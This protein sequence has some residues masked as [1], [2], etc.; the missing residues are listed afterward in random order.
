[1]KLKSWQALTLTVVLSIICGAQLCFG[2]G[3]ALYEGS[4]R[5]NA[6]GGATVGRADDPSAL[7][8][9]PAGIT[10]LPGTQVMAGA[11]FIMPKTDVTTHATSG[12]PGITTTSESNVWIPPH[13]YLTYQ[14]TDKVWLGLGMFSPFGL[15]TE[16]NAAWPGR[17]NNYN[18]VIQTFT[19]NP[20]IAFKLN[21][22]VSMAVGF[23]FMY[24]KLKLNQKITLNSA[25]S[26]AVGDVDQSLKG[27]S[28][29]LGMNFALHY[30]ACDWLKLGASYRS[31][32]T[33]SVGGDATYTKPNATQPYP[34]NV[35]YSRYFANGKVGGDVTLPDE[36]FF[37]AAFYPMQKLSFEVGGVWTHWSTYNALIIEY[38]NLN[39]VGSSSKTRIKNWDDTWRLFFGVEYNVT[40]WLDLRAGFVW[41]QEPVNSNYVDYLVPANDR[42]LISFGPGFKWRNWSLDLSYTYLI[43]T[44]RDYVA[45]RPDE[46]VLTSSFSNGYAHMIGCSI[47]Y[48][49]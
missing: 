27:D 10:Q 35:L 5:G 32:V 8:F 23:D 29:G 2:A 3:F 25:L 31:Q 37:G 30:K 9:N 12:A 18:A 15:G 26:S 36:V 20:N 33:Q 42:Y 24:F 21:D 38:D 1:M 34:Y 43:I 16:F 48:K 14:A 44:D 6:L 19:V 47:G 11:T 13:L 40:D 7:F 49:F 4:A 22:K 46:G 17:Y 41:D 39:S 28:L 45:A